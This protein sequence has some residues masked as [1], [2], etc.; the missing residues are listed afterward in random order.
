MDIHRKGGDARERRVSRW[1]DSRVMVG[2][3]GGA[4]YLQP[5]LLRQR[6]VQRGE[7]AAWCDA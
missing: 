4:S 5:K 7:V 6:V 1:G 2:G 3:G